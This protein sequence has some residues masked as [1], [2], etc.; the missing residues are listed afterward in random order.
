M[1]SH[2]LTTRAAIPRLLRHAACLLAALLTFH[3]IAQSPPPAQ[4]PDATRDLKPVR[5]PETAEPG[6]TAV[7]NSYALII[8]IAHYA[9]LPASAELKYPDRDAQSIYT[10]LISQQG[11]DFPAE[12]V[13]MLTDAQATRSNILHELETWLPSVTHPDDRVLIYFAGHGFIARGKA[14]LAPY[15]VNLSQVATTGIPMDELGTDIGTKIQGKWK[16]LLTDACHSGAIT[17]ETNPALLNQSLLGLHQSIFSL[18]ASRDREPS[19]ESADWGGGHGIFTYYV[20]HGLEGAADT[21]GDGVVTADELAE[22]VHTNVRE[23]TGTRQNPTSERGSFDAGMVLAY[24]PAHTTTAKLPGLQYGTLVVQ[25]NMDN[26]ELWVDG[27]DMG[28]VSKA[29]ALRLPGLAPGSHT[30]KGVHLGYQP[31]GPREE[32]IYPGQET[33]VNLRILIARVRSQAATDDLDRGIDFY[34]KGMEANYRKA[35]ASF[36]QAVALDPTYS[37]AYLYLGRVEN[38]LFEDE[39]A[40]AAFE[41][42][43]AIDPDYEE[44]RVS[45]GAALLDTGALDDAVRQLNAAL[46]RKPDDGTALY[47]LSQAYARKGDYTDGKTTAERAVRATPANGEAHFWLAECERHL[48]EAAPAEAEYTRY[49]QLSSFDS[50]VGGNLNYYVAGFLL[51]AGKK[52]H[53]AQQDIWREQRGQANLG[54]CDTEWMQKRYDRAIPFCQEA[55][56]YL[57]ADLWANY[58][59]G[60][61]YIEQANAGAQSTA[62]QQSPETLLAEAR[63][64]FSNV[65]AANPDTEEAGRARQYISRIDTALAASR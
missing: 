23:A 36:E 30:I 31:D 34:K 44:A 28:I 26:T 43:I 59:L 2:T 13:R 62:A 35:A 63:T 49:L 55:L 58:R 25:T 32:I 17:P 18:T 56:H 64:H 53:A 9:N 61:I 50:G 12:H 51:G 38:A 29:A 57:P 4:Q 39:K 65:I 21:N 16:V 24:D 48:N 3:A 10:T 42:A 60:V 8:G 33:T 27:K 46:Q 20:V 45:Y 52:R 6:T 19:Y 41:K 15:D 1:I 11:G 7:P 37:Q 14:Y 22:Y 40:A 54:I 47:L 5:P